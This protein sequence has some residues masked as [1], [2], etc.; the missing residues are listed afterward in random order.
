MK[1]LHT[2]LK[3]VSTVGLCVFL[4]SHNNSRT[5]HQSGMKAKFIHVA[6]AYFTPIN[7]K[8]LEIDISCKQYFG[9]GGGGFCPSD[10]IIHCEKENCK[11]R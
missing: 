7:M 4:H 6:Q 11:K 5:V 8:V 1:Y 9:G 10:E 2:G 3:S